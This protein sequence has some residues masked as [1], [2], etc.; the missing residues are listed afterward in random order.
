[1]NAKISLDSFK[2]P[3]SA[4][5]AQLAAPTTSS[6]TRS[7]APLVV[8]SRYFGCSCD[9]TGMWQCWAIRLLSPSSGV[10]ARSSPVVLPLPYL[11]RS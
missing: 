4:V 6:R 1:M 11:R 8:T 7:S 3:A 10:S 5:S 9:A 2:W